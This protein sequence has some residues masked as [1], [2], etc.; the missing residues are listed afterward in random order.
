M[1]EEGRL[2]IRVRPHGDQDRNFVQASMVFIA[3]EFLKKTKKY[4]SKAQAESLDLFF[5]KE[6]FEREK[7]HL[8]DKFFDDY[9]APVADENNRVAALLERYGMIEK[10]GLFFPVLVQELEHLGEKVYFKPKREAIIDEVNRFVGFLE[11]YADRKTGDTTTPT[12]FGGAYLRCGIVIIAKKYKREVI[13][14]IEPYL[15]S[16]ER[17]ARAQDRDRLL[18]WLGRRGQRCVHGEH[19]ERGL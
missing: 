17:A 1:R 2:V 18:H 15:R 5:A 13:G 14:D 6:L 10:V 8:A 4:L 19:H 9:F 3:C 12:N 11:E 7:P 16:C